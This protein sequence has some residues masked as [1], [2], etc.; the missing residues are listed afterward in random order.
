[1][2]SDNF[3]RPKLLPLSHVTFEAIEISAIQKK[4]YNNVKKSVSSLLMDKLK[5]SKRLNLRLKSR[6][7]NANSELQV[8]P[9]SIATFPS[10]PPSLS[11]SAYIDRSENLPYRPLSRNLL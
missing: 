11:I 6:K 9:I 5:T 7:F 3:T 1:V 4:R 8:K 2:Y 10:S